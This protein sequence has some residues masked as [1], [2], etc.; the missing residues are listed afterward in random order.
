MFFLSSMNLYNYKSNVSNCLHWLL[1]QKLVDV[2][3]SLA[4][5]NMCLNL[6]EQKYHCE[7]GFFQVHW[8]AFH[9]PIQWWFLDFYYLRMNHLIG[10]KHCMILL[11]LLLLLLPSR[12]PKNLR[13]QLWGPLLPPLLCIFVTETSITIGRVYITYICLI[14]CNLLKVKIQ[15]IK[16]CFVYSYQIYFWIKYLTCSHSFCLPMTVILIDAYDEPHLFFSPAKPNQTNTATRRPR[17]LSNVY[18][19][20][21]DNPIFITRQVV[22][23]S[24]S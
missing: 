15:Y 14:R 10:T 6:L 20:D 16:K 17:E 19:T 3:L 5:L 7:L 13:A 24:L 1:P 8:I 18:Y 21:D 12:F 22:Q 2:S 23:R 11:R 9:L 4:T